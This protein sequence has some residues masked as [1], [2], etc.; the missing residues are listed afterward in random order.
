MI[1]QANNEDEFIAV[2]RRGYAKTLLLEVGSV[3]ENGDPDEAD[4]VMMLVDEDV[5]EQFCKKFLKA[6][7]SLMIYDDEAYDD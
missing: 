5:L 4:T 6:R 7:G 2:Y 1:A 3:D